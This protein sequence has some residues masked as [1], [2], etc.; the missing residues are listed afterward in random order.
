M[1]CGIDVIPRLLRSMKAVLTGKG[2]GWKGNDDDNCNQDGIDGGDPRSLKKDAETGGGH[3]S[4]V[5][6]H[7][8]ECES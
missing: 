7:H 4:L 6:S 2:S 1:L 3:A 5:A 8:C